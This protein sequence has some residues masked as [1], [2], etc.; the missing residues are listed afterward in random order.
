MP[1]SI[2]FNNG[3]H[4]VDTI[5]DTGIKLDVDPKYDLQSYQLLSGSS[6]IDGGVAV[7]DWNGEQV[8]NRDS[9]EFA[10]T[11]PD[12][13]AKESGI[14]GGGGSEGGEG[15][16]TSPIVNAGNNQ[17]TLD[18]SSSIVLQG[19]VSDDG[20][21]ISPGEVTA[22]W[23]QDDGPGVVTFIDET[24][25]T[26]TASFSQQGKYQLRLRGDDG[27]LTASDSVVVRYANGGSG[28]TVSIQTPGDTYFEAE[29]YAYLYGTAQEINDSNASGDATIEATDGFG[30]DAFS[31]HTLVVTDQNVTFN[32]WILG[33]GIDESSDSILVTFE[34]SPE[35]EVTL[36]SDDT[37]NWFKVPGGF[38]TSA[39]SW[40]LIIR[41]G[42]D[43][44]IW[45]RILFTTD[46]DFV[47]RINQAP[48]VSAGS[49]QTITLPNAATLN[50]TVSDDGLPNSTGDSNN[51]LE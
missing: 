16:N 10:G 44:V 42:E 31:E 17:V 35:I 40:P 15:T 29:D 8:L 3:T 2:F 19:Q 49:N 13:G 41:A 14:E 11:A 6:S 24:D 7:F 30:I 33:K 5:T 43:G 9:A 28:N 51:R 27:E 26:T 45:D 23:T 38:T 34:N 32:L 46:L 36:S 47:P 21:P 20:L 4:T 12:L 50:G 18:P 39:G 25:P 48:T 1:H 37:Y 22:T